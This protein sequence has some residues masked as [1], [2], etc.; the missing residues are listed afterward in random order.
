MPVRDHGLIKTAQTL[1]FC[2]QL[3]RYKS[4]GVK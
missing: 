3:E 4:L 1:I 2:E